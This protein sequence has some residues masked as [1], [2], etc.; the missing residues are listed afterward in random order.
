M[1]L[2]L[3]Q[4]AQ[5]NLTGNASYYTNI[6]LQSVRVLKILHDHTRH[7]LP[8]SVMTYIAHSLC[9]DDADTHYNR[10]CDVLDTAWKQPNQ[11]WC[12]ESSWINFNSNVSDAIIVQCY[13]V[14]QYFAC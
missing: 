1:Y 14:Q 9:L 3:Q 11:R 4:H 5:A 10:E 13:Y 8:S 12:Y 2:A 7:V 6:A